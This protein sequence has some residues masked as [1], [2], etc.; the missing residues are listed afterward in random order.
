MKIAIKACL[1]AKWNMNINACQFF[2]LFYM[3]V[4]SFRQGFQYFILDL[5][6]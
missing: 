3:P 5:N 6:D 4:T 1:F 2:K